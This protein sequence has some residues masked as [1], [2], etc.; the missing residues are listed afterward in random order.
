MPDQETWDRVL[1]FKR[2][3]AAHARR[4]LEETIQRACPGP[5]VLVQHR[6]RLPAWCHACGRDGT[7]QRQ[8]DL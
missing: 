6:D 1:T 5:H 8:R 7:G 2:R 3:S 4:E